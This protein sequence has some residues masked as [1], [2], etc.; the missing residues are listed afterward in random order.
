MTRVPAPSLPNL[1]A[2]LL[3]LVWLIVPD[4]VKVWPLATLMEV[5]VELSLTTKPF[6]ALV[7][8]LT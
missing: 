5:F 1:V 7:V 4:I 6:V 3:P 2:L 8:V